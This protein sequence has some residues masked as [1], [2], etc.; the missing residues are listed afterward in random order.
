MMSSFR[1]AEGVLAG[2]AGA[3]AGIL[4]YSAPDEDERRHITTAL[5][6]DSYNL[7]SALD[8][9]EVSRLEASPDG[10][11]I[12][13]KRPKSATLG[14]QF[15]LE[16]SSVGLFLQKDRLV[17]IMREGDI[18]TTAK[19]FQKVT[20]PADVL[21]RFLLHTIRHYVGHLKAIKHISSQVESRI[22]S[23]MENRYLLQMFALSESLV[24]YLDAIEANGAVLSKL[25]GAA[26]RL[27]LPKEQIEL[28]DDVSLE[29]NQ[30]ARQANIYSTVL[31]GLMDARGTIVNNN[32]NTLL[33]NLTLINIVFLPLNLLASIGGMSEFSMMTR[34]VDWRVAYALFSL[35]MVVCGWL[36]WFLVVRL[37][38]KSPNG[39]PG[40]ARARWR[41]SRGWHQGRAT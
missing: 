34:G 22:T 2:D 14:E 41:L 16:V 8:P 1:I 28:L 19:E 40:L 11:S 3:G 30:C 24:Y 5:G 7:E 9:D 17:I 13:W 25:R 6:V 15:Q 38:E 37:I 26:E 27:A 21:I 32:M 31:S 10:V 20:S 12:I 4:V 33:K 29:N 18:P 39:R 23:S 36:T 35:G